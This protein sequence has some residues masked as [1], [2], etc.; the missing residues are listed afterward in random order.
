MKMDRFSTGSI[1]IAAVLLAGLLLATSAAGQITFRFK[2]KKKS[3]AKVVSMGM[4]G[5][6]AQQIK[7]VQQ[8]FDRNRRTLR[9]VPGPAGEPAY[10]REEVAGLI[11]CAG[12]DLDQA[13]ETVGEPGLE[14]LRAWSAEELQNIQRQLPEPPVQAAGSFPGFS[15][16][17]AVAVVASLQDL[18]LPRLASANGASRSETVPAETSNRLLDQVGEVISRIFVL[19]ERDDLEVELWVGSTPAPRATFSFW[20]QGKVKGATAAQT[21][22]ETNSKRRRVLRGLYAYKAAWTQGAVTEL[23]EYPGSTAAQIPSERLDLVSESRFFCCRFNDKYCNHVDSE[24][25]CRP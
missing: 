18:T 14:G 22:V 24:K 7:E 13:I 17:R 23:I 19:A 5:A 15:T 2:S 9:T 25:E 12:E 3:T 4:A 6:L 8:R 11:A 1:R 10:P 21:I 16:P 20:S